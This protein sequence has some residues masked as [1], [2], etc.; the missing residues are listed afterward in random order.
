MC[1]NLE[2]NTPAYLTTISEIQ[3]V[4]AVLLCCPSMEERCERCRHID[5]TLKN[6]AASL[7]SSE[8][9]VVAVIYRHFNPLLLIL[10]WNKRMKDLV[11]PR[12]CKP[13]CQRRKLSTADNNKNLDIDNN[14][15]QSCAVQASISESFWNLKSFQKSSSDLHCGVVSRQ[16]WR[17][18]L[19]LWKT[20]QD[21]NNSFK[22][23]L[24]TW[25]Q[26][27]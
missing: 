23:E 14:F 12:G 20:W 7:L 8:M 11:L 15:Y 16:L 5:L 19:L 26:W 9:W 2:T 24:S 17:Q 4:L 25:D 6:E 10:F 18:L 13:D 21:I 22:L 1:I 3:G 27:Y